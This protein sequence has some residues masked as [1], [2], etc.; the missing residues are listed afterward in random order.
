MAEIYPSK[1]FG[2]YPKS[3]RKVFLFLK[4]LPDDYQVWHHLAPWQKHMPD[5]LIISSD[6]KALML[7]VSSATSKELK[8]PLQMMLLNKEEDDFGIYEIKVLR[9]FYKDIKKWKTSHIFSDFSGCPQEK[10]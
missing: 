1:P 2:S 8:S 6:R 5:F 4:T 3:V 7:K 10:P 9:K